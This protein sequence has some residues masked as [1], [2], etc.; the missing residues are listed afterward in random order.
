MWHLINHCQ[1]V[2]W[3]PDGSSVKKRITYGIATLNNYLLHFKIWPLQKIGLP[4]N[5]FVNI[6][7]Y[8]FFNNKTIEAH[9]KVKR[10]H[11][12]PPLTAMLSSRNPLQTPQLRPLSLPVWTSARELHVGWNPI[13][14]RWVRSPCNT[15]QADRTRPRNKRDNWTGILSTTASNP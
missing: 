9:S 6:Y 5:L 1:N 14:Y 4:F 15:S 11:K 13:V 8:I 3:K 2:C 10:H 7:I 12:G